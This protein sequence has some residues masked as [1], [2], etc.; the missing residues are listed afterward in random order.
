M[1]ETGLLD[2]DKTYFETSS[3]P[4]EEHKIRREAAVYSVYLPTELLEYMVDKTAQ[5]SVT[6]GET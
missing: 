1:A 4:P 5:G 3:H 6:A 2:H